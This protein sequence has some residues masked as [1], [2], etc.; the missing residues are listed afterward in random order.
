ML[1]YQNILNDEY[2]LRHSKN[3]AYSM[4]SFARDLGLSQSFLSQVI[5]KKRKLSDEAGLIISE[6]LKLKG[7]KRNLF[8]NLVRYDKISDQEGKRI[9][10]DEIEKLI[11]RQAN[12]K[13]L[14]EDVFNAVSDWHYFAILELTVLRGF[15]G[16]LLWISKKL[17]I[18]LIEVKI[19]VEC[20]LRLGLLAKVGGTL[21]KTEKNYIFENV[22]SKAIKKHHRDTLALAHKALEEQNMDQREFFTVILPMD[23]VK[24]KE[25]KR[26]IREFSD[27][28]TTELQNS[29]PKSIYKLAIQ[30]F[31][32]DREGV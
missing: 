27:E 23:P 1:S 4:R 8:V 10:A 14:A 13:P 12:F 6:K 9:L 22:P 31:R 28:M 29:E 21:V 32:L 25:V 2:L 26:K 20:L 11:N 17:K 19:A 3:P 30:F 24:M 7:I 18:P 15:K 5:N 16:D